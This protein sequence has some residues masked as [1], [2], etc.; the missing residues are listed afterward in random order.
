MS[1]NFSQSTPGISSSSNFSAVSHCFPLVTPGR[2][3]TLAMFC[4][5]I[6]LMTVD[7]PTFGTPTNM[8]LGF[9]F[10]LFLT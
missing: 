8:I 4:P 7:L 5:M 9:S 6:M 1:V 3:S 2:F 10:A